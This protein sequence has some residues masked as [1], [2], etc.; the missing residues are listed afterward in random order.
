MGGRAEVPT[1]HVLGLLSNVRLWLPPL[2]RRV[3]RLGSP[4]RSRIGDQPVRPSAMAAPP[5]ALPKGAMVASTRPARAS[6]RAPWRRAGRVPTR[7]ASLEAAQATSRRTWCHRPAVRRPRRT[8]RCGYLETR[9]CWGRRCRA[10]RLQMRHELCGRVCQRRHT[11]MRQVQP[12]VARLRMRHMP[13][14]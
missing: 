14:G 6:P 10:D 3:W 1:W 5:R 4:S 9:P 2:H 13:R 12:R 11:S 8:P 7:K